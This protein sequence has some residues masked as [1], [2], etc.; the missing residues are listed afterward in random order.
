MPNVTPSPSS[1]PTAPRRSLPRSLALLLAFWI[2]YTFALM[3]AGAIVGGTLGVLFIPAAR[4]DAVS[5]FVLDYELP[6]IAGLFALV[7]A[8]PAAFKPQAPPRFFG[9][10]L[11]LLGRT[12]LIG[13]GLTLGLAIITGFLAE[14]ILWLRPHETTTVN[15]TLAGTWKYLK[16][17][18]ALFSFLQAN[19][20]ICRNLRF[21]LPRTAPRA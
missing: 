3:V 13:T 15:A 12:F 8:V 14:F 1:Q 7:Y 10:F 17:P 21:K 20:I 11:N 5:H 16:I 18:L 2:I 6:W 19:L 4:Q 9:P